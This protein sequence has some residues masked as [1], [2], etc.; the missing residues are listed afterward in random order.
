MEGG[1][2]GITSLASCVMVNCSHMFPCFSHW[3]VFARL[4]EPHRFHCFVWN[5]K[6]LFGN[7]GLLPTEL[8]KGNNVLVVG[9]SNSLCGL[10]KIVDEITDDKI[11]HVNLPLSINDKTSNPSSQ[12]RR[13]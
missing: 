3:H 7:V 9:H 5:A 8:R 6:N 12:K 4:L 10:V 13:I 11:E 2:E 1:G